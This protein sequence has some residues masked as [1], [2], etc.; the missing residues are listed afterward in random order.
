MHPGGGPRAAVRA[1]NDCSV[2]SNRSAGPLRLPNLSS[3]SS[4]GP[5]SIRHHCSRPGP[6]RSRPDFGIVPDS[7]RSQIAFF[8]LFFFSFASIVPLH[9]AVPHQQ[10]NS[11]SNFLVRRSDGIIL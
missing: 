7:E 4:I 9:F 3:I 10:A 2:Y 1:G 5:L 6:A 8:F 11:F